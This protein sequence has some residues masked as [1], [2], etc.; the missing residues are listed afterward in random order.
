MST[1]TVRSLLCISAVLLSFQPFSLASAADQ[2]ESL[3][4]KPVSE[5]RLREVEIYGEESSEFETGVLGDVYGIVL[6]SDNVLHILDK[7]FGCVFRY[8]YDG[9]YLGKYVSPGE[10]P[11]DAYVPTAIAIDK[12]DH[13]YVGGMGPLISIFDK[14][15]T[16]VGAFRRD[17]DTSGSPVKSIVVDDQGYIYVCAV[18]VLHQKVIYKYSP[19]VHEV[20]D[21]F[22]DTFAVKH[23]VDTRAERVFGGGSLS[24]FGDN[25]LLYSQFTPP[26]VITFD[27]N[28]DVIRELNT[29]GFDIG[30]PET[31]VEGESIRF[32]TPAMISGSA[33]PLPGDMILV[34]TV[35]PDRSPNRSRSAFSGTVFLDV[36]DLHGVHKS[37]VEYDRVFSPK[38]A[39]PDGSVF[40]F[41]HR[42]IADVVYPV[43][44]RYEL[45]TPL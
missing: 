18:D 29:R 36:Y 23:D 24:L 45:A 43:V 3:N 33:I 20:V 21:R 2:L 35:M 31:E 22:G 10:G 40:V 17:K 8:S 26:N 39:T 13:I 11:G 7:G 34:N 9:K 27:L 37:A 6:D 32:H 5:L 4:L 41:E 38:L 28:G 30:L 19:T 15:G 1:Y 16:P 14:H 12:D 44:V 42:E 25:T